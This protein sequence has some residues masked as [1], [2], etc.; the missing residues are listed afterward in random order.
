MGLRSSFAIRVTSKRTEV[1]S[2]SAW[3]P[4]NGVESS[5]YVKVSC[6]IKNTTLLY[7]LLLKRNDRK[8]KIQIF[9]LKEKNYVLKKQTNGEKN[10]KALIGSHTIDY[11]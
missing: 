5:L 4:E 7:S 10:E 1:Y 2:E 9:N 6:F 3:R 11:I 8:M